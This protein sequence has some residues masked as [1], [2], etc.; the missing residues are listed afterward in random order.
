[1]SFRKV[2]IILGVFLLVGLAGCTKTYNISVNYDDEAGVVEGGGEYQEGEGVTLIADPNKGYIFDKWT[3]NGKK[4][5]IYK[6]YHFEADK[7]RELVAE[8]NRIKYR[9]RVNLDNRGAGQVQGAGTYKYGQEVIVEAKTNE[10][11]ELISWQNAPENAEI[12]GNTIKFKITSDV[13]LLAVT[14]KV[15]VDWEKYIVKDNFEGTL[16]GVSVGDKGY[17]INESGE[18]AIKGSESWSSYHRNTSIIIEN[19]WILRALNIVLFFNEK[20][21]LLSEMPLGR[22]FPNSYLEEGDYSINH[23]QYGVLSY[24]GGKYGFIDYEGNKIINCKYDVVPALTNN[25]RPLLN[26]SFPRL[27]IFSKDGK[28][29]ALDTK[30]GDTLIDFEFQELK[31]VSRNEGIIYGLKDSS[32]YLFDDKGNTITVLDNVELERKEYNSQI[33]IYKKDNQYGVIDLITGELLTKPIFDDFRSRIRENILGVKKDGFWGVVD[34]KGQYIL[35]PEF[36]E[37]LFCD[38]AGSEIGFKKGLE[39]GFVDIEGNHIISGEY[40]SIRSFRTYMTY[41]IESKTGIIIDGEIAEEHKFDGHSDTAFHRS[42]DPPS[43]LRI[44]GYPKFKKNNYW[45]VYSVNKKEFITDF[46]Y[47]NNFILN[48]DSIPQMET[49]IKGQEGEGLLNVKNGEFIIEPGTY[50][51]FDYLKNGLAKVWKD[52]KVGY[53][54]KEGKIVIETLYDDIT[55]HPNNMLLAKKNGLYGF[56]DENGSIIVEFKY[57]KI[58]HLGNKFLAKEDDKYILIDENED[59]LAEFKYDEVKNINGLD[60]IFLAKDDS[61][62]IL[63]DQDGNILKEFK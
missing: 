4:I 19:P 7:D 26:K 56:L 57:D 48:Y 23:N 53:V 6:K 21:D 11:H 62:Y 9:V 50:D 16:Y 47:E 46:L 17:Y 8:F 55:R 33:S 24:E 15:K 13:N 31:W 14:E 59:I 61:R 39:K 32:S 1:M 44:E 58:T 51:N 2:C 45:A 63:V 5:P 54:N 52:D 41:E 30:T 42:H 35:K 12:D 28:F 49:S 34:H 10:T 38:T 37:V 22:L 40:D 27:I 25:G 20:G 60:D 43:H 3:E 36:D 18:V 29:G